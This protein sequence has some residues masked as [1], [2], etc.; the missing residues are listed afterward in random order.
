MINNLVEM[1]CHILPGIDD[2]SQDIETSIG[3][4][5]RLKN[6]GAKKIVLTP[7]Y[8]SDTIS[9]DDF[10]RRREA[11]Y[12][13]LVKEL[14][15]GYPT[16]YPAAEVYISPY[17]FNNDNI[18]E[19]KIAGSDYVLIEHPFSS[20]FG[21]AEYDKLM[22]LYCDYRVRPVLAHIERYAALMED[23]YK[24][25]D[26]IEMGCLTQVNIGTFADAPRGVRKKL[27]KLLQNGKIHLIGSDAHNLDSRPPEYENG[28]NAI[29]KKCGQEAVDTLI[30]N[31]NILVK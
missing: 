9:L 26:F 24:L 11:S 21:E 12:N 17:L 29:V 4:I 6:Q 2:G 30:Q 19:L 13:A 23:K 28:I 15:S 31:A 20:P 22:N 7:H 14:P 8:Y 25:D 10:L 3:M 27:L 1:H 5:E 18:D 16:L